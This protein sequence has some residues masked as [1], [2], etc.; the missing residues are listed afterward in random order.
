MYLGAVAG[1]ACGY[2][3]DSILITVAGAFAAGAFGALIYSFLTVTLKADQNVTGLT[4][5]I[6]G[7]GVCNM[8]GALINNAAKAAGA[9]AKL[10]ENVM[11]AYASFDRA[12]SVPVGEEIP[13]EVYLDKVLNGVNPF[14]IAAVII[15][16]VMALVFRHSRVGLNPVSY[17]HLDVYKR[18]E[19]TIADSIAVGVPRNPVKALRA[20]KNS[21]GTW[22]A[23]SDDDI[24]DAMRILGRTEGVF[25]EPAG[26]TATAGVRAAVAQGLIKSNESVTAIS[27]GSGLKD[28]KNA[29]RAAG[30]PTLCDPSLEAL[31]ESG[32][33]N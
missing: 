8:L 13:L 2:Y 30:T 9:T 11:R 14:V 31:E 24:L 16:V 18:Q 6:F 27:T 21:G 19:N 23:V 17:T 4:L 15:A 32:I 28:V 10:S 22:I 20:V 1:F 3:T 26:V 29:L 25:G 12:L 7:T 5:T 33:L